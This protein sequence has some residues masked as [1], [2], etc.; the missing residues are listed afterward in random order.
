MSGRDGAAA[1]LRAELE[2]L[3]IT[4]ACELGDGV[5]LSVWVGLVVR[6]RDG[7]YRWRE[8]SVKCRHLGT[9]PTG[10]AIRIARRHAELQTDVP[11]WW[12]DLAK[13]LREEAAED[14][15]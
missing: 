13:I 15:R 3:G 8:G 1:A 6:F 7:F 11:L 5:T 4:G 12:E 2:R 10:C 14:R 9:D